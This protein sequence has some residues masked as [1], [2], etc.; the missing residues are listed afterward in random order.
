MRPVTV[1]Y[2]NMIAE[3]AGGW[4]QTAGDGSERP[5]CIR[6][7]DGRIWPHVGLDMEAGDRAYRVLYTGDAIEGMLGTEIHDVTNGTMRTTCRVS[8]RRTGGVYAAIATTPLVLL[9]LSM[10]PWLF[11]GMAPPFVLVMMLL[12]AALVPAILGTVQGAVNR[13]RN[14]RD[15]IALDGCR[16]L[17][18]HVIDQDVAAWK[19]RLMDALPNVNGGRSAVIRGAS[20]RVVE[21]ISSVGGNVPV[22]VR[23]GRQIA[24]PL[25]AIARCRLEDGDLVHALVPAGRIPETPIAVSSPLNGLTWTDSTIAGGPD[26][27]PHRAAM[28]AT[29]GRAAWDVVTREWDEIGRRRRSP[30]RA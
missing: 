27:H 24:I 8:F 29:L 16:R 13:R 10:M 22:I 15:G 5:S 11:V 4:V 12:S 19:E 20:C 23:P 17:A 30:R 26:G 7:D 14:R 2:S 25:E 21:G 1:S 9:A 18:V 6:L 3:V 28:R